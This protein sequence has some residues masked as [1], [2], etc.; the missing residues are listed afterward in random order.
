MMEEAGDLY[1]KEHPQ[2]ENKTS[3]N[4]TDKKL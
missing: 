3:V 4:A 2:K 1:F